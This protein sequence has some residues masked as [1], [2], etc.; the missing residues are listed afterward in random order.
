MKIAK[1]KVCVRPEGKRR[2]E[3]PAEYR[4]ET[5]Q[6]C[7]KKESCRTEKIPRRV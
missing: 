5:Y 4:T 2:I 1:K 3:I 7:V 6:E